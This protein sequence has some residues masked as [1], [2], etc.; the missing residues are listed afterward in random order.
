MPAYFQ[1]KCFLPFLFVSNPNRIFADLLL[2]RFGGSSFR[3]KIKNGAPYGM[4]KKLIC[5]KEW[6][7]LFGVVG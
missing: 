3:I 7:A 1:T 4:K 5:L 2:N 6:N